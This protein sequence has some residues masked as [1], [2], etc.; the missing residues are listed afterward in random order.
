MENSLEN[1]LTITNL[2]K[3]ISGQKIVDNVS[4]QIK[5]GDIYGF[6]GPNGA[7][8]TTTLR[9]IMQ[10]VFPD[11]GEIFISNKSV[12]K[13]AI[14]ALSKVGSIIEN[15]TFY[16]HLTAFQNLKLSAILS[17]ETIDNARIHEVL[18][19]V[20]LSHVKEKRVKTF[21]L[22]MK[23][24][25]GLANALLG[26]PRLIILD[27]PTNGVD[28]QGLRELKVI[29]KKLAAKE[30]ITFLISS[31]ML[32]EMDG[33]CHKAAFIQRGK[34]VEH[35]EIPSLMKKYHVS[36]LED[37]FFACIEEEK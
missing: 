2:N 18:T 7:G 1:V 30:H 15:P 4:L 33:L 12:A 8:K 13:N 36:N 29:I 23:Q 34:I 25:L 9:M 14:Q 17:L 21:S 26:H 16:L 5:E 3:S 28:P 20:G 32:R 37:L 24:R 11:S 10:L 6:L 22:G 27:E 31:H 19:I 35:G